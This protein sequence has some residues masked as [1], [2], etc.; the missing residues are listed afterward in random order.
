MTLDEFYKEKNLL[1]EEYFSII[2][3]SDK[4]AFTKDNNPFT[5]KKPFLEKI[6]KLK[7]QL[8]PK[9]LE[10]V[11]FRQKSWQDKVQSSID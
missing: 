11:N 4:N 3:N 7:E 5:I 9:D 8:S 6:E 10:V 2:D 1:F